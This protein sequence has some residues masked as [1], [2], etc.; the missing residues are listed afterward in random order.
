MRTLTLEELPALEGAT[1]G[2]SP[3]LTI[4]QD[5]IDQFAEATEDRQWIHTD[6]EAAAAG[7][8]GTT[9]AHGYL[10]LSSSPRLMSEL[11]TVRCGQTLNYGIEKV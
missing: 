6:P 7:P 5:R 3:W 1:F 4:E 8:F 10:T 9:V 11:V 2:P